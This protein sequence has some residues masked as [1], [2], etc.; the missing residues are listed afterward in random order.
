[1]SDQAIFNSYILLTLCLAML[2]VAKLLQG[3]QEYDRERRRLLL[4]WE[5]RSEKMRKLRDE[6]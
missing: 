1:M 6:S 4:A 5:E 2:F 3:W